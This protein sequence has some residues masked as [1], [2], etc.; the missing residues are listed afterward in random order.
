M[1]EAEVGGAHTCHEKVGGA[2]MEEEVGK[3]HVHDCAHILTIPST[4]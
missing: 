1:M 3:S 2:H 4:T